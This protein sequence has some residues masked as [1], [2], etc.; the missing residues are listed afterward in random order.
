MP[1]KRSSRSVSAM[2]KWES[3]PTW[4]ATFANFAQKFSDDHLKQ[5]QALIKAGNAYFNMGNMPEAEKNYTMAVSIYDKFHKSSDIDVGNIAEAYYK[6]G[7]IYYKKFQLIKLTAR[8]EREMKTL[9]AD[10]SKALEDADKQYAKAIEI[11]VEEWTIKATFMIGQ[12]FVEMAE[13]VSG[14][15]L[16]GSPAERIASK[17]KILS[18]LEKYYLKTVNTSIKI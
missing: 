4:Q 18:S 8:S 5:V 11:G 7:E 3:S 13:A 6:T 9:V 16:F 10:K 12:G 1:Q 2:K 14:Q 15:T 17:I